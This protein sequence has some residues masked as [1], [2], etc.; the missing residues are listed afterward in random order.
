[1][2]A[3]NTL[4]MDREGLP[5]RLEHQCG[6]SFLGVSVYLCCVVRPPHLPLCGVRAVHA[7][8]VWFF[9]VV[10]CGVSPLAVP[11]IQSPQ[12]A[13]LLP[14]LFSTRAHPFVPPP[15]PSTAWPTC[16]DTDVPAVPLALLPTR[17]PAPCHRGPAT[18]PRGRAAFT[19]CPV[20]HGGLPRSVLPVPW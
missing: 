12:Q 20:R 6:S 5:T 16:I 13:P 10:L 11:A 4:A 3:L 2:S 9:D 14:K 17:C 8:H 7:W 19:P 18:T 15:V 1:M